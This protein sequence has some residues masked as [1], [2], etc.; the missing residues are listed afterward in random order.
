MKL[1]ILILIIILILNNLGK[2]EDF[3]SFNKISNYY[4]INLDRHQDRRKYMENQFQNHKLSINRFKAFDKNLINQAYLDDLE[5]KNIILSKTQIKNK[6]KE[7][8][9]AC[10]IS[11]TNLW[12]KILLEGKGDISL[13]FEDDCRILPNFQHKLDTVLQNVP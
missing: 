8:S 13:I 9:L 7:G 12:K 4:Y 5:D 11:H 3:S 1:V 2:K 10:L 6:K